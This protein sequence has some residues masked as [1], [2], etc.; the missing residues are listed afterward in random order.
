MGGPTDLSLGRAATGRLPVEVTFGGIRK[1][2]KSVLC[3]RHPASQT[4]R[5]TPAPEWVDAPSAL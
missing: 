1:S 5:A 3:L 4:G 2:M